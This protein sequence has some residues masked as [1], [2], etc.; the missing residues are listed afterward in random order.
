MAMHVVAVILALLTI[1]NPSH[2]PDLL[3]D[4]D[5]AVMIQT[6]QQRQDPLSWFSGDWPLKN[7]FYRPVSAL[8]FEMDLA[9]G[10]PEPAIF[11][12]TNAVLVGLCILALYWVAWEVLSKP[13]AIVAPLAFT[14]WCFDRSDLLY[15]TACAVGLTT[16]IAWSARLSTRKPS[17]GNALAGICGLIFCTDLAIGVRTLNFR[18]IGWIPGRTASTMALFGLLAIGAYLR[19]VRKECPLWLTTSALST[20]LALGAYEQAVVLPAIMVILAFTGIKAMPKSGRIWWVGIPCLM[21]ALY[22]V[23][24]LRAVPIGASGYQMQQ[25]RSGPGVW[26][27]LCEY[28]APG[29]VHLP[30]LLTSVSVGAS[31]LLLPTLYAQASRIIATPVTLA[32]L[33]KLQE[34]RLILACF[35]AAGVSFAPM[36]WFK[37]FDHYHFLPMA[38]RALVLAAITEQVWRKV[39]SP[40]LAA[41][42]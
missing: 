18:M 20:L 39:V 35:I 6:I 19:S 37:E 27:S 9:K 41:K 5:T 7:H 31:A 40:Q 36:A 23:I 38:L 25:F 16:L 26:V 13:V 14:A 42:S 3:R 22:A 10:E 29:L 11:A 24:R 15:W 2:S 4:S 8:T 1:L 21:V 34:Y 12:Q 30:Y 33:I 28:F 32:N 17:M